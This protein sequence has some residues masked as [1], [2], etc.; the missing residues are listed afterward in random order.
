MV[1]WVKQSPFY[2]KC[3]MPLGLECC[4]CCCCLGIAPRAQVERLVTSPLSVTRL[5]QSHAIVVR[6]HVRKSNVVTLTPETVDT[7]GRIFHL[8]C[9][10]VRATG[11]SLPCRRYLLAPLTGNKEESKCLM[12]LRVK[13]SLFSPM[14]NTPLHSIYQ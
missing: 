10:L 11:G 4:S 14:Y 2:T 7:V 5:H 3:V 12:V 13:P 6:L 8:G 9:C 1:L